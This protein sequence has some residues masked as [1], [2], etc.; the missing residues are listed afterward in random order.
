M[1]QDRPAASI[2][3][4]AYNEEGAIAED[5]TNLKQVLGEA[6]LSYEIIVVNDGSKDRTAEEAARVP[7]IR[8]VSH[9]HNRGYGAS[10]KT[11]IRE[12]QSEVIVITDADGTYP[13]RYIPQLC[14]DI[15][16]GADMA[17]GARTGKGVAIPSL[18]KPAKWFLSRLANY[19]SGRNIPDLNSGLRAFRRTEVLRFFPILPSGFSFTTTITLAMLCNDYQVTYQPIEY[20]ARVGTSKIRPFKDTYNFIVLVIRTICY[21][22]PL[23]VFLPP[24]F[25]MLLVGVVKLLEG[26]I[27]EHNFGHGHGKWVLG[28]VQMFAMGIVADMVSRLIGA[29]GHAHDASFVRPE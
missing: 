1:T 19:L 7:G 14:A 4:P 6:R 25:L 29:R 15:A 13:P 28:A 11:G 9:L 26:V 2:V 16:A 20:L 24:A 3:V 21:F 5:L 12:A 18:R 17:V 23:K 10:L 22:N 8:L 27:F